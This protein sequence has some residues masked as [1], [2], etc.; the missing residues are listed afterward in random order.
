MK[1]KRTMKG[2]MIAAGICSVLLFS[3]SKKDDTGSTDPGATVPAVKIPTVTATDA[4]GGITSTSANSGGNI[5]SN[6]GAAI[7]SAGVCWSTGIQPT[8]AD[9]KSDV[10]A[11]VPGSFV[12]SLTGLTPNT[13]YYAKAYATNSAGT[14]YGPRIMFTTLP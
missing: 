5:S 11:S 12:T 6:G 2:L 8:I 1:F 14:A 7:T 9:S 13:T 10:G 3:C 4:A